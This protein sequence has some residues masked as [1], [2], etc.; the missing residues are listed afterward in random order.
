MPP[1][2]QGAAKTAAGGSSVRGRTK[3]EQDQ[4]QRK[5]VYR[6]VLDNPLTVAW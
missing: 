1:K 2:P 6:P 3:Q 4:L 5:S